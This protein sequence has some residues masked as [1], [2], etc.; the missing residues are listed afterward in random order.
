MFLHVFAHVY[1]HH[2]ALVV[3]EGFRKGLCKL[4]FANAGGTEEQEGAYGLIRVLKACTGAEYCIAYSLHSLVLAYYPA[5]KYAIQMQQLFPL[6]FHQLAYGYAG[7][8][9]HYAGYLLLGYPVAEE[10]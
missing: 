9:A 5:V 7:P 1:A 4:G 3:E 10:S 6:P 2:V 8:A